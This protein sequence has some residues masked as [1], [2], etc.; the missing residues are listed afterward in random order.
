MRQCNFKVDFIEFFANMAN[1]EFFEGVHQT[2]HDPVGSG[3]LRLDY[4]ISFF[5][6]S[7]L[8]GYR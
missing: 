7:L 2:P 5:L 3:Y 6:K 4:F 1:G 8:S